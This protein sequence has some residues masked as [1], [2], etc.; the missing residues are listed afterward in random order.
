METEIFTVCDFAQ[1]NNG[2][3]TIVG[4][5][6]RITPPAF[7][8]VHPTFSI[9]VRLRFSQKELGSHKFQL[10]LNAPDES[11]VLPIVE[12]DIQVNKNP[13][14]DYTAINFAV[15]LNQVRF[16]KPGKYTIELFM[17]EEW[18]SGLTLTLSNR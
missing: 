18:I 3:L 10:K 1:D 5:F 4:T 17:D 14:T 6:D 7:P 9:A 11:Q 13:E 2:K 8:H 12:G 15:N 16:E